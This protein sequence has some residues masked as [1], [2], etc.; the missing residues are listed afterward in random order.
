MGRHRATAAALVLLGVLAGLL[1]VIIASRV[2][3]VELPG[4]PCGNVATNRVLVVGL[5]SLTMALIVTPFAFLAELLARRRIVYRGAWWRATRR[6]LLAGLGVAAL[7]GLRLGD[8]LTPP[9]AIFVV[10]AAIG[11]EWFASRNVDI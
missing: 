9:V 10:V 6:G 7:G 5:A 1:L 4:Q 3:P 2:C 11:L 8:A